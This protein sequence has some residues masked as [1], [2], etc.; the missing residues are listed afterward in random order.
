M[1]CFCRGTPQ[2]GGRW[3]RALSA[4]TAN[5]AISSFVTVAYPTTLGIGDLLA[6]AVTGAYGYSMASNYNMAL[7]PPVVFVSQGSYRVVRRRETYKDLLR[8]DA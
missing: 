8:L 3:P 2:R 5:P 7:R 6:T 4:S 1:R